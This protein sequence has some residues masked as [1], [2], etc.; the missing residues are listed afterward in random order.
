MATVIA[1]F[2]AGILPFGAAWME[3]VSLARL[4]RGF[5]LLTSRNSPYGNL[6]VVE[7]ENTRTLLENGLVLFTVPDPQAAEEAVHYAL[8]EH[9][10]PKTVL[11]I[12]GELNGSVAEVLKH[13]LVGAGGCGRT[14]SQ[15][16]RT[17][18]QATSPMQL[19]RCSVIRGCEFT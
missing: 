9:S 11:L 10:A 3:S 8:L 19:V 13:P 16:V 2:V 12:G 14:R 4:W 5:H 17:R 1:G 15:D 18:G 7:T 6:A